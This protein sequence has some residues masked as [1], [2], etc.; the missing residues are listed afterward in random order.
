MKVLRKQ[1]RDASPRRQSQKPP[2]IG[3]FP[4][5]DPFYRLPLS[6][7]SDQN[8][9]FV[10]RFKCFCPY[11]E[12]YRTV[13]GDIV[14]PRIERIIYKFCCAVAPRHNNCCIYM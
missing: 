5:R 2:T 3:V 6:P 11:D 13:R 12:K 7:L 9:F 14:S 1:R 10:I 4:A 8:F